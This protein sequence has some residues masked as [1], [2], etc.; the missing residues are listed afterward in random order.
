MS[1]KKERG[2]AQYYSVDVLTDNK[3]YVKKAEWFSMNIV[4]VFIKLL[5]EMI[6]VG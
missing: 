4:N 3:E 2:K 5:E 6:N 1:G